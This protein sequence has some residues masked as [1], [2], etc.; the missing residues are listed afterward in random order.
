VRAGASPAPDASWSAFAPIGASGDPAGAVG[1][2]AQYRA[3]LA[4]GDPA[5]TPVLDGVE[6]ACAFA[7]PDADGDGLPNEAETGTGIFVSSTDTGTDPLDPDSDDDGSLDG[8]EVLH[9]S[10]P[11]DADSIPPVPVPSLGPAG[12]LGLAALLLGL[13]AR[14]LRRRARG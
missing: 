3:E 6:L 14:G 9:G 5:A 2:Y 11:N 7:A 13:G 10:D 12:L 8:F 1:R 4:T